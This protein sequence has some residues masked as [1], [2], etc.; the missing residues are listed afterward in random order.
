MWGSQTALDLDNYV[1]ERFSIYTTGESWECLLRPGVGTAFL[2]PFTISA[3]TTLSSKWFQSMIVFG[4]NEAYSSWERTSVWYAI[5]QTLGDFVSSNVL[6][7][8]D[9]FALVA[10][11]S[12]CVSSV[13]FS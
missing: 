7:S 8:S 4:K 12:T 3:R 13:V 9:R 11:L 10:T 2:K 1:A 6:N 5:S